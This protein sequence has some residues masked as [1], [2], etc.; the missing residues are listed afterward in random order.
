[1]INV[2]TTCTQSQQG[3]Q[4]EHATKAENRMSLIDWQPIGNTKEADREV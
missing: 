1:M 4:T 3:K 2:S